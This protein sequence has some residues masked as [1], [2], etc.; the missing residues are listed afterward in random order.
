MPIYFNINIA[1]KDQN[2]Q[3]VSIKKG[4]MTFILAGLNNLYLKVRFK[5][6][7]IFKF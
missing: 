7:L 2:N 6:K 4:K 5:K 1:H 3:N